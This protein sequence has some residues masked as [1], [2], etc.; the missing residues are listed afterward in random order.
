MQAT[1]R[2]LQDIAEADALRPALRDIMFAAS[3]TTSFE[4]TE[5]KQAFQWR[6]LDQF[7]THDPQW[8]YVALAPDVG[9]APSDHVLGYLVAHLEDPAHNARFADL[10]Y[11]QDFRHITRSFPA[12]LH[13][14]LTARARGNGFGTALIDAFVRDAQQER[15]P[16][17]HV[18]TGAGARNVSF[19]TRAGFDER[20]RTSWNGAVLVCLARAL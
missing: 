15:C 11:F 17:V 4:S 20:A 12:Q 14:N 8:V 3:N 5:A 19:Y 6:W 13:V 2:R 7:L 16:G 1:V 18:V 9:A 10:G